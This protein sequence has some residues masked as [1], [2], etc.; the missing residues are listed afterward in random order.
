LTETITATGWFLRRGDQLNKTNPDNFL[1]R[2]HQ[3]LLLN[4]FCTA[5]M[6][7]AMPRVVA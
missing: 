2:Q 7:K 4:L 6:M 1:R 3:G 5:D